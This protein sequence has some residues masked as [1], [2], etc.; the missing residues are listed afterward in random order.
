[1]TFNK[2]IFTGDMLRPSEDGSGSNQMVNIEWL[3]NLL[4]TP[5]K[6]RVNIDIGVL[7]WDK[8][9]GSFDSKI[10]YELNGHTSLPKD[11]IELYK[12]QEYSKDSLEYFSDFFE[13]SLVIGFELPEIFMTMLDELKISYIDV[14]NHP[15]RFLDD[16]F[17][18]MKTNNDRIFNRLKEYC[19]NEKTY[20]LFAGVHKSTVSRMNKRN[21]PDGSALFTGQVEIDK[22]LIQNGKVLTFL[23]FKNEFEA[24]TKK[25][26]KV[27]YKKHPYAGDNSEINEFL[28]KFKNVEFIDD[29]FYH[30][31]GNDNLTHVYSI[32]SS[33]V[34][35]AKMWGKEADYFYKSPF[36]LWDSFSPGSSEFDYVSIYNEFLD[37]NFWA[38][39]LQDI[40][41]VNSSDKNLIVPSPKTSRL[42]NS[43]QYYWGYNFLDT[44]ILIENSGTITR[45]NSLKEQLINIQDDIKQDFLNILSNTKSNHVPNIQSILNN[46]EGAVVNKR[47]ELEKLTLKNND[48]NAM[49]QKININD[50]KKYVLHDFYA[51]KSV[52]FVDNAIKSI[53]KRAPTQHE[54]QF[55]SFALRNK[56]MK[57]IVILSNLLKTDEAIKQAVTV[58]GL[59]RKLFI[60]HFFEM[61]K[62]LY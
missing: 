39:I 36:N 44:D 43:L 37:P 35:E 54:L 12:Y 28:S 3:Y 53:L 61:W 42:R 52:N 4:S 16:I 6:S 51:Y 58:K 23:D 20:R 8:K 57:K 29:N 11:W 27:Y 5:I 47:N 60:S 25:H 33:T 31:L 18:G 56:E 30:L 10:F 19:I 1:M 32:S 62:A 7:N 38:D 46:I 13:N 22:S 2:I 55:Y 59:K 49:V 34:Y 14:I 48:G 50:V 40:F 24:V 15:I 21:I 9:K 17:F 45:F 26:K 41:Q